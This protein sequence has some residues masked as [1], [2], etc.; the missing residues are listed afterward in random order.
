MMLSEVVNGTKYYYPA[1]KFLSSRHA[2]LMMDHG[3]VFLPR[4]E[5]F[6]D[7]GLHSGLILDEAECSL[8]LHN[9]Y[10]FYEGLAKDAH[11]LIPHRF[12]PFTTVRIS[13]ELK[14]HLSL[15]NIFGY[16][17][18]QD[19][20]TDSFEWAVS[21]RNKEACVMI[22]NVEEFISR[23][24]PV[25]VEKGL[26]YGEAGACIYMAD[27][28]RRVIDVNPMPGSISNAILSKPVLAA[29]IKPKKYSAQ[30]ELRVV[31]QAPDEHL[32]IPPLD[33]PSIRDLLLFIDISKIDKDRYFT[34]EEK[35]GTLGLRIH[36]KDGTAKTFGI[37]QPRR[38]FAPVLFDD[39]NGVRKFA[40][41]QNRDSHVIDHAYL[42]AQSISWYAPRV[43]LH[44]TP[45]H[46]I[47]HLEFFTPSPDERGFVEGPPAAD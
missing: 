20:L 8:H 18:T 31:W 35:D 30:R 44:Q 33:I 41:W 43:F 46:E 5:T 34:D 4:M 12:P 40:L 27:D 16:C 37:K 19:L 21:E 26:V 17:M 22:T 11:G 1:F 42:E 39:A 2:R 9:L 32:N 36:L 3:N 7:A 15:T 47:D 29:L 13:G 14:E 6:K 23:I 10:S 28:A 38:V 24:V 45:L 25:F